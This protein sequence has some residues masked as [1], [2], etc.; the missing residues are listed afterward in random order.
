MEEVSKLG[1]I[2]YQGKNLEDGLLDCKK[3]ANALFG[4]D[5]ALRHFLN[6]QSPELQKYEYEI[7]VKVTTGSWE[8]LIPTSALDW[9]IATAG[10]LGF[11]YTKKAVEKMAENDFKNVGFKDIVQKSIEAIKWFAKIGMHTGDLTIKT[12]SEVKFSEN[13]ALIGIKNR[14]GEYLYVPKY[15]LDLYTSAN[16]NLIEKL[17]Q[18]ITEEHQLIIGTI[19]NGENQEVVITNSHKSIFCKEDNDEELFPELKHGD[20]VSL[21]G[22]VTRENKTTNNMGFKYL[23]HILTAY[24]ESGNIVEY[25]PLLF[26]NCRLYGVVSRA[27]EKGNI[28]LKKPKLIFSQIEALE[29]VVSNHSLF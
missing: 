3:Q 5:N 16:P 20:L 6:K 18:N 10:T 17:A 13:N 21:E 28:T 22:E 29:N 1:Y 24:P 25:K 19:E 26:L 27:D 2:K 8:A 7:P 9:I 15:I 23:D 4:L 14:K 11:V 12:F